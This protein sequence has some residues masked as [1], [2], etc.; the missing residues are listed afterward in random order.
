MFTPGSRAGP[1]LCVRG[2]VQGLYGVKVMGAA[3]LHKGHK[4]MWILSQNH[5]SMKSI[6]SVVFL[7]LTLVEK[8]ILLWLILSSLSQNLLHKVLIW[9]YLVL[10]VV[11]APHHPKE[12]DSI[13]SEAIII[14][15][16]L[17]CLHDEYDLLFICKLVFFIVV[18]CLFWGC[19]CG[20]FF[21]ICL[22]T[23]T[24]FL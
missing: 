24:I 8:L 19:C 2:L 21:A 5:V 3:V 18:C 11:V 6:F 23:V 13:F 10:P 9:L 20:I 12:I 15:P 4:E 14:Q 16:Q 22:K 17:C 7:G 1:Q